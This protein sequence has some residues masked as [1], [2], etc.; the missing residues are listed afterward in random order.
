MPFRLK[1]SDNQERLTFFRKKNEN[2][3]MGRHTRQIFSPNFFKVHMMVWSKNYV[4]MLQCK[5][6]GG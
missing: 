3:N 1:E 6:K 2:E 4:I 5:K